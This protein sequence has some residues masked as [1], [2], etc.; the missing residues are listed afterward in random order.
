M[1]FS[2]IQMSASPQFYYSSSFESEPTAEESL[3]DGVDMAKFVH[4]LSI[5][6]PVLSAQHVFQCATISLFLGENENC[7]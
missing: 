7:A 1:S 5:M 6:N 3:D 2:F 4:T